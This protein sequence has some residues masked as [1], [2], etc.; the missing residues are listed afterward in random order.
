MRAK[1]KYHLRQ[2]IFNY[3]DN[4]TLLESETKKTQ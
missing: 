2:R 3:F 1:R 4:G